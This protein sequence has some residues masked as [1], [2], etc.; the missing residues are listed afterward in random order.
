MAE[1]NGIDSNAVYQ[2][3]R[4]VAD[5]VIDLRREMAEVKHELNGK[6]D[7]S[8]ITALRSEVGGLRA[9]VGGLRQAVT[10]YHSS[11]LGHGIL[12][13]ELEARVRRVEDHLQLPPMIAAE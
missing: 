4:T 5:N 10:Q 12:I 13:G 8:D 9:E 6:A 11:V 3:L 1:G 2:L 7:K